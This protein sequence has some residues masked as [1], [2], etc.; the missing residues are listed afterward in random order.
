MKELQYK[1]YS[2]WM[3]ARDFNKEREYWLNEFNSEIPLLNIPTDFIRPKIKSFIGS[4]I[5]I[6]LD[7]ELTKKINNYSK[8]YKCTNFMFFLSAV[9]V[10]LSFYANQN[11][12][13][14]GT[15]VSAR[16]NK[17]TEEM[18][19]L[20]SNTIAIKGKIETNKRFVDFLNEIKK[21]CIMAFEN[22]E[23]PFDDLVDNLKLERDPSRNPLF[24]VMFLYQEE[25]NEEK[26]NMGGIEV[27]EIHTETKVTKFDLTFIVKK[28]KESFVIQIEYS[29]DLFLESTIENI[30]NYLVHLLKEITEK[31]DI[32]IE[33]ISLSAP[34]DEKRILYEFND[35]DYKFENKT[36]IEL[37]EQQVKKTPNNVALIFEDTELSY[38]ELNSR[39]NVVANNLIKSSIKPNDLV[40]IIAYRSIEMIIGIFGILKAGAAYVPISPD[41]PK[42]RIDFILDDC[43]SNV[44]LTYRYDIGANYNTIDLENLTATAEEEKN[45]IMKRDPESSIY[46]I[47]TSGTT[48]N[49]KG[50][51]NTNKGLTNR[52]LWMQKEY[53]INKDDVILQ[54]T[55]YTFDVSFWELVWWG[56]VGAKLSILPHGAE[57]DPEKIYAVIKKSK[58][59][60]LHFVPSMFNVT[61][62]YLK[63]NKSN[64]FQNIKYIFSSGEALNPGTVNKAYELIKKESSNTEIINLYGPTEASIDVTYYN[65]RADKIYDKIPIGKPISNIKIFIVKNNSLCGIC[66]PGEICISG[67]GLAKGYLNRKELS[68]EK[69][70]SNALGDGLLYHTG[71]YGRW[72]NDGK[73]EYLG[74]IDNQI[75]VRGFRIEL[76]EI[77]SKIRECDYVKDVAVV[78]KTNNES[79]KLICAYVVFDGEEMISELRNYL[80][81]NIPPY[82]VPNYFFGVIE[83]PKTINGKVDVSMLKIQIK[84]VLPEKTEDYNEVE[85]QIFKIW[86]ET[87]HNNNIKL[88]D[89]FFSIGGNS[90]NAIRAFIKINQCY[91][92]KVKIPDLFSNTTIR[93]LSTYIINN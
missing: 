66:M 34:D 47:Y 49:P 10:L 14:I 91:P 16:L 69:F 28:K 31:I 30:K 37:F 4:S 63:D 7:N 85:M 45:I 70:T 64:F 60:V 55:S 84:E 79:E 62:S 75:K 24:D 39:A 61:L 58:V 11:D 54:K 86:C 36:L 89:D 93:S 19:G 74:R 83:I 43:G 67:I 12:I 3:R 82:M 1:D 44:V 8:E 81:N 41:F 21:K 51:I 57:K 80:K 6:E 9:M 40:P 15:P 68:D 46:C 42:N 92:G 2:E 76:G 88:D 17:E 23:Y 35:T 65:C 20:F 78:I 72:L 18:L 59:T 29:K 22:Q 27:E 50:V 52:I 48:G 13:V 26:L 38:L 53:P 33:D 25:E 56:I 5:E 32:K 90:L 71:D 77:E 87:L 73:I